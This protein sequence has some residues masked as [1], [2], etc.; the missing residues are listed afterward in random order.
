V[1]LRASSEIEGS[2]VELS[3][4]TAGGDSGV[5]DGDLLVPFAEAAVA[6]DDEAL[7]SVRARVAERLG[8]ESLVDA[9]AIVANFQRMVRIADGTGIPLDSPL[10]M[11]S[12]DL[13]S[14][15]GIDAYGSA[16]A[17]PPVSG[18]GSLLGKLMAPFLP[19]MFKVFGPSRHS[20]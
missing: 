7:A 2:D 8:P 3:G 17:T 9:A 5:P 6:H 12:V 18:A 11:V 16:D 4:V 13:R 1:L 14:E 10:A 19:L 15:L 20:S